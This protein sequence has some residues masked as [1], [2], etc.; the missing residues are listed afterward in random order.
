MTALPNELCDRVDRWV[1]T[2]EELID[3]LRIWREK[4]CTYA[5]VE[6]RRIRDLAQHGLN[7]MEKTNAE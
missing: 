6:L 2:G 3:H 1:D 7:V 5:E 4:D